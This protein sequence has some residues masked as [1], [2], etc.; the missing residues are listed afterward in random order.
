MWAI[1]TGIVRGKLVNDPRLK[2]RFLDRDLPHPLGLAAG[3]DKDGVAID[4]WEN[5]G[6][7]F[8][9]IGTVTPLPQPGNERPRLFRLTEDIAL[10]NRMGF[11]NHG[12]RQ[13]RKRLEARQTSI[14]IGVNIGKNQTTPLEDA[15]SDYVSCLKEVAPHADYVAVNISSP[16][17]PGLRELQTAARAVNLLSALRDTAPSA[18]LFLKISPDLNNDEIATLAALAAEKQFDGI[19]ATNTTTS[20]CDTKSK[21]ANEPGGLSGAP[22]TKLAN[23][24]CQIVSAEVGSALQIIGVGGIM[25]GADLFE[26]LRSGAQVCQ[27]YT[28]FVYRGPNAPALILEE[29]L[30]IMEERCISSLTDIRNL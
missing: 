10:V 25:T 14:P 2:C 22:L 8:A 17:T 15:T 7:S 9:E 13:L 27:I 19:I 30:E 20:R 1:S 4:E 6:F 24:A 28:A 21:N 11:N 16:N 18:R 12:V 29:L 26:R 3:F 5:M 23:N